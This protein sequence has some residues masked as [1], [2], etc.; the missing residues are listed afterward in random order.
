M[1]EFISASIDYTKFKRK[2]EDHK[3]HKNIRIRYGLICGARSD[4]EMAMRKDEGFKSFSLAQQLLYRVEQEIKAM[5]REL[6]DE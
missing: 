2:F 6:E 3:Q 5:D 4:I 1:S